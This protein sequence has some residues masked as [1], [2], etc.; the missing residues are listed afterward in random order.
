[1]PPLRFTCEADLEMPGPD[2]ANYS[3]FIEFEEQA[4]PMVWV[5][6]QVDLPYY[7]GALQTGRQIHLE[8]VGKS[9]GLATVIGL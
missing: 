2:H 5:K 8:H 6:A 4:T 3:A 7:R 9:I 1:M